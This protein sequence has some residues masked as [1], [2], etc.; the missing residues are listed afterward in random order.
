MWYSGDGLVEY[1][2]SVSPT[3]EHWTITISTGSGMV[4]T[5]THA[6]DNHLLKL[7]PNGLNGR[8]IHAIGAGGIGISAVMQ[9]ARAQGASV[10]GCDMA[11]SSMWRLLASWGFPMVLGHAATHLSAAASPIDLV[12]S[13]PAVA[14]LDPDNPEVLAA[15]A[16]HIPLVDWQEFLGYLMLGKTG[17]SVAGVHGK[18]STTALLAELAIAG[19]LDP[20]AEVGAIVPAW[21]TNVRM[22]QGAYFINEADEWNYNFLHYHP[23]VVV[24]TAVEF[25]HPEFFSSYEAIRDAFLRFL[26]GMD[27]SSNTSGGLRPTLILNADDR[28]CLDIRDHLGTGWGGDM[29]TFGIHAP[30]AQTRATDIQ[31]ANETQFHL[32]V[33]QSD[34][35]RV[36]LRTPGIHNLY[37]ALAA[38]ATADALGVPR[39]TFAPVLATF[40]G[41][42]RRFQ[43]SEDTR[44]VVYIDDYAHHPH[45]VQLTLET[46]RLLYPARRLVAVFQPTLYTRLHRF[47]APF[48]AAFDAADMVVIVEIQPAREHDTGLI[49]GRD[50]VQAIQ[51]RPAHLAHPSLVLYGGNYQETI[52]MVQPLLQPNDVLVVM[53]SGPVNQ[54]IP[55]LRDTQ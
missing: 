53:G 6:S 20:T 48:S 26:A 29:R 32:T 50:L 31:L 33:A 22:G 28:G 38:V 9:L 30:D 49:H 35:G 52:A 34:I 11:E 43:C 41:L 1:N 2:R 27:Q 14:K 47:L 21:G 55:P 19:G 7:F 15:H 5:N 16:L 40:A 3:D 17:V 36:T 51:Q 13:A 39:E 24:L 42:R 18:G 4:D 23:R 44:G 8:H 12:V 46:A 10:S 45:A 54:I 25:D 37:N